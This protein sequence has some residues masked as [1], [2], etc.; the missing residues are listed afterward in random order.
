[1]TKTAEINQFAGLAE[2]VKQVRAGN[3]VV[4]TEGNKPVARIVS[5]VAK[6]ITSGTKLPITSYKGRKVLTPKISSAEIMDEMTSAGWPPTEKFTDEDEEGLLR[7]IHVDR[8]K[9]RGA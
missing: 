9:H 5:T 6:E 7:E 1:M 4:L 8:K 3:E 2:L